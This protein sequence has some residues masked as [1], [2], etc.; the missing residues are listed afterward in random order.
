MD[1]PTPND[2]SFFWQTI[3]VLVALLSVFCSIAIL[4]SKLEKEDK[5]LR[6]LVVFLLLLA[7][8]LIYLIRGRKVSK[9]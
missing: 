8:A 9:D 4:K 3:I 1:V 2:W 6:V 7:G 5:V